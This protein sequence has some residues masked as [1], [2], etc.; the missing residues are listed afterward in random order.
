[1]RILPILRVIWLIPYMWIKGLLNKNKDLATNYA[2]CH[3]NSKRLL[4]YMG[5]KLNIRGLEN[6]E[7]DGVLFVCNHQGTIDPLLI[8]AA[9]KKP[10]SFIS[11]KE[12]EKLPLMG[13]WAQ[14]IKTIHFDRETREGNVYMLRESLR[15][16]KN[17]QNLLLFPEGT[18]S[19]GDKM[20]D[21]KEKSL[22][23]ALM[24]KVTIVPVS[25]S[26]AYCLDR[27]DVN[28][29]DLYITFDKAIKY[30]E[31][32]NMSAEELGEHVHK[33]IENNII[34]LEA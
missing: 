15:Y 28:I 31:Y 29:K 10:L 5:Y 7:N 14:N 12:N 23:I 6:V 34:S 16:L 4:R 17:K 22:Q 26:G 21:F 25:I 11:K 32:K 33:I 27:K 1:M 18:R 19:K 9:L 20:N 8:C 2:L 3:K 30:E 13:R 24:S